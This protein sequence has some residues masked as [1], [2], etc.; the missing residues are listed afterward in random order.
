MKMNQSSKANLSDNELS[1]KVEYATW[2]KGD[3]KIYNVVF[4][5][6]SKTKKQFKVEITYVHNSETKLISNKDYESGKKT[7]HQC[8]QIYCAK[9]TRSASARE[10][11]DPSNP[12]YLL[13]HRLADFHLEGKH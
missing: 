6:G 2:I 1:A 13:D 10:F 7:F 12:M 5:K 4:A 8:K 3:D 9:F 11:S